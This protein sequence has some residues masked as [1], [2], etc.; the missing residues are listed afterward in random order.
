MAGQYWDYSISRR[1]WEKLGWEVQQQRRIGI[2]AFFL[3][4]NGMPGTDEERWVRAEFADKYN[5]E[6]WRLEAVA[7]SYIVDISA[8]W[9]H[10]IIK[11]LV[12]VLLLPPGEIT[13]DTALPTDHGLHQYLVGRLLHE[14]LDSRIVFRKNLYSCK[15]LKDLVCAITQP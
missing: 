12:E 2:R 8:R 11:H 7:S 5:T 9:K 1:D 14:G 6:L 10:T 4:Q 15:T 13:E 3:K